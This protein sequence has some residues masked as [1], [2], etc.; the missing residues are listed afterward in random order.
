MTEMEP[1]EDALQ[2]EMDR[3]LRRSMAAPIPSLP[4]EFDQRWMNE[5]RRRSQP[6]NRYRRNLLTGYG[7]ASVVASAV[8]M[9]GQGINW[10]TTAVMILAPLALAAAIPWAW[11]IVQKA[12]RQ[13][14]NQI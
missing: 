5:V 13:S 6:S 2:S 3:L 7:L 1:R 4:P 11:R 8:V 9:R 12:P 10:E 14:V